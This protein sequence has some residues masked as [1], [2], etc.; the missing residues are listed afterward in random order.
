MAAFARER[1]DIGFIGAR[2]DR[3]LNAAVQLI[4]PWHDRVN[5]TERRLHVRQLLK[6]P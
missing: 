2:H 5:E 6:L 3:L 1:N 4:E